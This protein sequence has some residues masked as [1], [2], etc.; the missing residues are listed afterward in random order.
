MMMLMLLRCVS[1]LTTNG[2]THNRPGR[3][4]WGLGNS[5]VFIEQ[6]LWGGLEA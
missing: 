3:L 1:F 6:R 2:P 4:I 5:A